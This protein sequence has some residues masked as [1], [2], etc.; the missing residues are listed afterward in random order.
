[1][2]ARD[3]AQTLAAVRALRDRAHRDRPSPRRRAAGQG[4]GAGGALGGADPLGARARLRSRPRPRL[5]RR[6]GRR[7]DPADPLRDHLRLRVGDGPAHR[8]L[9]PG[10]GGR[11]PGR[12]PARAPVPLRRPRKAAPL[13]GPQGGV[14]PGRL[15]ARPGG[16][17]RARARPRRRRSRWS[18]RRRR[19]RSI[20]ASRTISSGRSW[21]GCAATQVVV[22]PRTAEQRAELQRGRRLHRPRARRST[23]SRWSP[24][25]TS[26]C[27]PAGTMNR[28][29]VAL[30]TPVFTVFEGRLGAVDERLIAEGRLRRLARRG[31]GRAGQAAGADGVGRARPARPGAARRPALVC[32]GLASDLALAQGSAQPPQARGSQRVC[33]AGTVRGFSCQT[34]R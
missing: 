29:A 27:P 23:P 14:L 8:Q 32:A 34:P 15:R 6:H 12:D 11:G 30:G 16:A 31:R 20:T 28:E 24:T 4:A 17:R 7:G 2:T 10:P 1:M 19:C 18:A 9:P 3:F 25:P 33:G 22:L 26:W 13:P 5:Q 21:S